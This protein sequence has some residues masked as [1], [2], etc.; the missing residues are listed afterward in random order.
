[1]QKQSQV[2]I[3]VEG[4][5]GSILEFCEIAQGRAAILFDWSSTQRIGIRSASKPPCPVV[6]PSLKI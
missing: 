3:P 1:M 2:Q 4:K 5:N 6:R